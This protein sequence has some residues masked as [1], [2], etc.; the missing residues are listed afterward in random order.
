MI[1][2]SNLEQ[3]KR[4]KKEVQRRRELQSVEG[5]ASGWPREAGQVAR[6]KM[7]TEERKQ[8]WHLPE[9]N[10]ARAMG[11]MWRVAVKSD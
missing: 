7:R 3:G 6:K 9:P 2:Q 4:K 11:G 8:T 1:G 10:C 5:E